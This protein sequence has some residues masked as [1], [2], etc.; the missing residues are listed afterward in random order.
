MGPENAELWVGRPGSRGNIVVQPST[1]PESWSSEN[2]R[3]GR[4]PPFLTLT[5]LPECPA[6]PMTLKLS[7]DSTWSRNW[8]GGSTV[9]SNCRLILNEEPQFVGE[10]WLATPDV[11]AVF[12]YSKCLLDSPTAGSFS[13]LLDRKD[14]EVTGESYIHRNDRPRVAD[15]EKGFPGFAFTP[16][17][18]RWALFELN[19]PTSL[20]LI[21]WTLEG[22]S[23]SREKICERKSRVEDVHGF[24]DSEI[25]AK[26]GRGTAE[27]AWWVE[28]FGIIWRKHRIRG[29]NLKCSFV[30]WLLGI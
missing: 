2:L 12:M 7:A 19:S 27:A 11:G 5:R 13:M 16:R 4:D 26:V 25:F 15:P 3:R 17:T 30:M 8:L 20:V 14:F 6:G 28:T 1:N 21:T 29:K 10:K 23:M 9:L 22:T 18:L 24:W